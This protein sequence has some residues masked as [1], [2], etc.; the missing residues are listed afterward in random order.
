[1]FEQE[2]CIYHWRIIKRDH[3]PDGVRVRSKKCEHRCV[4]AWEPGLL[5]KIPGVEGTR[6]SGTSR[7]M[8]N[9]GVTELASDRVSDERE[10]ENISAK[11]FINRAALR[12]G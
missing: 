4:H 1:M 6:D 12:S 10:N 2:R 7:T 3:H 8:I 9:R 5:I 11:P